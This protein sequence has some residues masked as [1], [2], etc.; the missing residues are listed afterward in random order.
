M[1]ADYIRFKTLQIRFPLLFPLNSSSVAKT[2]PFSTVWQ[3]FIYSESFYS[4]SLSDVC[5]EWD[6]QTQN[7][8]FQCGNILYVMHIISCTFLQKS[9]WYVW[10]LCLVAQRQSALTTLFRF[11]EVR[12]V[13]LRGRDEE[14]QRSQVD[15][16]H[17]L[18]SFILA[19]FFHMP[20]LPCRV[21]V[22]SNPSVARVRSQR[23]RAIFPKLFT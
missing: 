22:E 16:K 1:A 6:T 19:D 8:T 17:C 2:I 3:F 14:R 23:A 20:A 11:S 13:N 21:R 15:V 7:S 10:C 18:F 9:T 4:N 5:A 12:R